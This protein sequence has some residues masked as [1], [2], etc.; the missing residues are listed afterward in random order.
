RL[1]T[2]MQALV[3]HLHAFIREVRLTEAEWNQAIGFLTAAGHLTD[4]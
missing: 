2:L 3:K 1:R 4:D